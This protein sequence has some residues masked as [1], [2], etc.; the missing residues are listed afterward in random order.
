MRTRVQTVLLVFGILVVAA[1]AVPLLLFTASDRTQQLVLARSSSTRTFA[2]AT[3]T[4]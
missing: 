3:A 4:W 1:F 2:R